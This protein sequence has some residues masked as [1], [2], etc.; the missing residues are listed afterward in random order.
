M[1]DNMNDNMNDKKMGVTG[2]PYTKREENINMLT[3]YI[4]EIIVS[5]G[6]GCLITLSVLTGSAVKIVS[7]SIYCFSMITLYCASTLYHFAES[8]SAKKKL[9]V[10]D[11]SSIYLLIAGTYTPFLLININGVTGIT[12]FIIVWSMALLGIAAKIF[13]I[14]KIKKIS[15]LVYLVMG[16]LI[17]FAIKPFIEATNLSGI[18]FI[19]LGGLFYSGGVYFYI[20]K[21][22]EFYHGIW[23]IFVLLGTVAHFFA[24]LYGSILPIKS[25]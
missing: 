1:N 20:R 12:L 11:H 8:E 10:I 18:I 21:D 19:V 24:V 15:L 16:W 14:N 7:V 25:M 22:K 4:G 6:A 5:L 13:L 9:K 17:V 3:H 2:K 23:H